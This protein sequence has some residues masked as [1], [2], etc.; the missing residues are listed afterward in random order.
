MSTEKFAANFCSIAIERINKER[1]P[2][3]SKE[4]N[5]TARSPGQVVEILDYVING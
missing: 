2:M 3:A 5:A 1:S 4:A